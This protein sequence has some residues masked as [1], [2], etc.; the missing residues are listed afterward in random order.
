MSNDQ[1]IK[2]AIEAWINQLRNKDKFY[3]GMVVDEW[4][5]VVGDIISKETESLFFKGNNLYVKVKSQALKHELEFAKKKLVKNLN[6]KVGKD[7]VNE[8]MFL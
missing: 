5:N 2:E 3:Q 7:I 1:T 4:H 8:I 6:K